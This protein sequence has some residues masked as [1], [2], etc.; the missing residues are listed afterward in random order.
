MALKATVHKVKLQI[1]DMD[2][3]YYAEHTMTLARHPSEN[4][5]RMMVRLLAFAHHAN[6]SLHFG[7]GVSAE[8]EPDIWQK[9]LT[10]AIEL[11][12]QLGQ[13]DE[14]TLRKACGQARKV[15][16][17]SYSGHGAQVW[18]EQIG[19]KLKGLENLVVVDIGAGSV[20]SLAALS[21]KNMTLSCTIQ[22]SSTYMASLD[23]SVEVTMEIRH[24]LPS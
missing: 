20:T 12:V 9:D 7:R 1:A 10:G 22:D 3:H 23:D 16:V 13:P 2:R 14:K 18:W 4:D 17:Y 15:V 5:E 11:W 21:A 19:R 8:D 24:P 6:E